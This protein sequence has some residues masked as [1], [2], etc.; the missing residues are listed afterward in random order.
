MA[1]NGSIGRKEFYGVLGSILVVL[2]SGQLWVIDLTV[3]RMERMEQHL[4]EDT[5]DITDRLNAWVTGGVV[6]PISESETSE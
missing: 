6:V 2:A 5:D 4:S 3:G 1:D